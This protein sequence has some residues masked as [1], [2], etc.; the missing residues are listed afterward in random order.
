MLAAMTDAPTGDDVYGE[1]PTIRRLEAHVADLLGHEAG[2]FCV[3]GSLANWLALRV[4]AGPGEEVLCDSQSHVVRAELGAHAALGVAT[5]RTW[6]TEGAAGRPAGEV[7]PTTVLGMVAG[8]TSPYLVRTAVVAVENTHNFAGGVV[9][10]V[11]T[12]RR[13]RHGLDAA[14]VALHMDGARLWNAC[15]ATA[16]SAHEYGRCATT[17]S[18]CLSKGLGAPVGSVLV[19]ASAVIDE[20]RVWRKR[21]GAGWRQA[22][23]LAAAGLYALEHQMQ[24]LET[25]HHRARQIAAACHAVRPTCVTT[26]D[27]H[28]NIVMLSVRDAERVVRFAGERSVLVFALDATT[29]R[30]ITHRDLTDADVSHTAAVL[31]QAVDAD[32]ESDCEGNCPA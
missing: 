14:G 26:T 9:Q 23:V 18:V 32:A 28:T 29:V 30:A 15:V 20:A 3:T 5:T 10:P 22:G 4:Q 21:V 16:T 12:L 1:D 31:A 24:D 11:M 27:V 6:P 17:V 25:D 19:G 2:L 13:L 7:N 8:G